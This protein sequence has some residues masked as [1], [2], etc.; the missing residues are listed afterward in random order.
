M[1]RAGRDQEFVSWTWVMNSPPNFEFHLSVQH[2]DNFIGAV[3]EIL[4]ALTGRV[5]P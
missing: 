3:H 5:S 4:P 1:H 2:D